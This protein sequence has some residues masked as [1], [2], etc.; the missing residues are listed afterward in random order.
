[1]SVGDDKSLAVVSL[2]ISF[3]SSVDV[4][5]CNVVLLLVLVLIPI[6]IFAVVVVIGGVVLIDNIEDDG[7]CF[8]TV[9][10]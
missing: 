3:C 8:C 1:M 5:K 7:R 9:V 6:G 10:V 2:D 4:C